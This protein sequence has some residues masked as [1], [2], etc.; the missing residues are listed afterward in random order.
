MG[1]ISGRK[2]HQVLN[3]LEYILAIELL[4]ATQAFEFRRPL[5]TSKILETVFEAVRSEVPFASEDRI[6]AKD[7]EKLKQFIHL[8]KVDEISQAAASREDIDLL[9]DFT[10]FQL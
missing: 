6:F 8:G 9:G 1:S 7:V 3:N 10:A 4:N 2:L 5:K